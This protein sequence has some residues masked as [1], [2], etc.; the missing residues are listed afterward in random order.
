M[1]INNKE[2]LQNFLELNIKNIGSYALVTY[3]NHTQPI[4]IAKYEN[5]KEDGSDW[6]LESPCEI[7]SFNYDL[8]NKEHLECIKE[9]GFIIKNN[10]VY[11]IVSPQ[12]APF[13]PNELDDLTLISEEYCL[14]W[15]L[16][17]R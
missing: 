10:S 8:S 3:N 16:N 15:I 4:W 7:Y 11:E 17:N 5:W 12:V 14:D 1:K 9:Y 13:L 6:F 2:E